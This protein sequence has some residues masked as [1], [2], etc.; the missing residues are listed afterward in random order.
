MEYPISLTEFIEEQMTF[1]QIENNKKNFSKIY[2]KCQRTLISLGFWDKAELRLV[3]K[4]K[5]KFFNKNEIETLQKA[6]AEYFL[7]LSKFDKAILDKI[8]KDNWTNLFNNSDKNDYNKLDKNDINNSPIT[9]SELITVMLTT[10]FEEKYTIDTALWAEDK[11]FCNKLYK[12]DD[13][14]AQTEFIN[15]YEYIIRN[16]RLN[17]TQNYVKKKPLEINK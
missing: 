9:Q 1:Y 4:S 15:S 11:N 6:T 5:T 2:K 16:N 14:V 17:N 13:P 3:K 10:L 12:Y 8:K 7:K